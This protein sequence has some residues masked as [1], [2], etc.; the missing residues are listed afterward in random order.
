MKH[1]RLKISKM[2]A[3]LMNYLFYMGATDINIDFKIGDKY[4]KII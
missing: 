4:I 3:E 1:E 2:V